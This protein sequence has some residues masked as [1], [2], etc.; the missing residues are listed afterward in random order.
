MLMSTRAT[1]PRRPDEHRAWPRIKGAVSR[2]ML[3]ALIIVA[4]CILLVCCRLVLRTD[5]VSTHFAYVPIVLTGLWW[6]RRSVVVAAVLGAFVIGLK[7]L[8]ITHEPLSADAARA[9]MFL[10]VAFCVGTVSE[11][12]DRARRAEDESRRELRAAQRRLAA[13][14]RLASMGQ[15]SAG[16]AHEMNNP[17]GTILLYSH[18]LVKQLDED[19]PRRGDVQMVVNEATRCKTIVRGLLDFARQSRVSKSPTDPC[20]LIDDVMHIMGPRAQAAGV[21]LACDMGPG[22]PEMMLDGDQVKQ[23]LVN[24]VQNGID[25]TP[26]GGEVRVSAK[27]CAEGDAVQVTVSDTGCGIPAD[28]LSKLFTPFFTTKQMGDGTGLGLAIAYGIVKMHSGDISVQS[29]EGNGATFTV[30]LPTGEADDSGDTCVPG[31]GERG[32]T[33]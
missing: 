33:I 32:L 6:G 14:E 28:D 9:G 1:I 17:L 16:L 19:D 3:T 23:L 29:Q 4:C 22:L 24:L 10:G 15:L 8:G 5:I 11:R 18:M 7:L 25:A 31:T 2:R 20:A 13:S 21:R 30:R 12:A 27:R 26:A